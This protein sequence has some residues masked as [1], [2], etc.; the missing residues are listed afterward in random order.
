[1]GRRC[2][3]RARRGRIHD[4]MNVPR[5]GADDL[6]QFLCAGFTHGRVPPADAGRRE[7]YVRLW[8]AE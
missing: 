6:V 8:S 3:D 7:R 5:G 2:R 1:M 4:N